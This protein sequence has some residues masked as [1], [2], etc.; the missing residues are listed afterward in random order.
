MSKNPFFW[1]W[2]FCVHLLSDCTCFSFD[3][4][5][6]SQTSSVPVSLTPRVSYVRH[7]NVSLMWGYRWTTCIS[8]SRGRTKFLRQ[9]SFCVFRIEP[10]FSLDDWCLP[11][12][13][14]ILQGGI[15]LFLAYRIILTPFFFMVIFSLVSPIV[16]PFDTSNKMLKV[17]LTAWGTYR[18]SVNLT[19]YPPCSF[20][21]TVP[22]SSHFIFWT[23]P[24]VASIFHSSMLVNFFSRMSCAMMHRCLPTILQ[25]LLHFYFP[26]HLHR[27]CPPQRG[28]LH[29]LISLYSSTNNQL[30]CG[31]FFCSCGIIRWN[32]FFLH[33]C[34]HFPCFCLP[35]KQML[36]DHI[37]HIFCTFPWIT[38]PCFYFSLQYLVL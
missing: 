28:C 36:C 18:M 15:F 33:S 31:L 29:Y 38:C 16:D 17:L 22:F 30:P 27:M 19:V 32:R 24:T 3:I 25:G 8:I 5:Q 9:S 14:T 21:F 34:F 37:C 12:E 6:L 11:L 13:V 2:H 1:F 26:R 23:F 10:S 4:L 7:K 20:K 35:W